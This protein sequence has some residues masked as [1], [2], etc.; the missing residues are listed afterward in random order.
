MPLDVKMIVVV[1]GAAV[2]MATPHALHRDHVKLAMTDAAL[3]H[4]VVGQAPDGLH[5]A[6]Q[7]RDLQAG[8]MIEMDMQGCDLEVVMGVLRAGE[9]PAEIARRV[10]VDIGQGRDTG[11]V[12]LAIG[13]LVEA[14][15]RLQPAQE[16]AQGFGAARVAML[17]HVS[18]QRRDEVVID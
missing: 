6:L 11:A 17:L 13:V 1:C 15:P 14:L 5:R 2:R 3:A 12:V 16:V 18:I 8:L 9:P 4:R 7:H 10:V